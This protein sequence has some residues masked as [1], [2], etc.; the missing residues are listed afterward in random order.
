M[1]PAVLDGAVLMASLTGNPV[2]E[3]RVFQS[4]SQEAD[5]GNGN[6]CGWSRVQLQRGIVIRNGDRLASPRLP[7]QPSQQPRRLSD[8]GF[9]CD[10]VLLREVHAECT[11][12]S[13]AVH[14]C[15]P[16]TPPPDLERRSTNGSHLGSPPPRL[17]VRCVPHEAGP[18]GGRLSLDRV[19]DA[20]SPADAYEIDAARR[21]LRVL[22]RIQ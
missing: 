4:P 6:H 7:L 10:I 9:R 14:P 19:V 1:F 8:V 15:R 18:A 22:D 5:P 2:V 12:I 20:G 11:S 3:S 16:G 17:P 13:P 21:E